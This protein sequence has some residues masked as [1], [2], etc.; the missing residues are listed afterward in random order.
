MR[1]EDVPEGMSFFRSDNCVIK[2]LAFNIE[3]MTERIYNINNRRSAVKEIV[4]MRE[5]IKSNRL[6]ELRT[7]I[8]KISS[9]T[10]YVILIPHL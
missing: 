5:D 2:T 10:G 7:E 3:N 9:R 1:K 6:K 8:K 4:R